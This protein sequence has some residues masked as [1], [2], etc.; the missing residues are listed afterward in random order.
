HEAPF[1]APRH[2]VLVLLAEVLPLHEHFERRRKRVGVLLLVALD[3][4]RDLL[5]AEEELLLV[6]ILHQI[7][8]RRRGRRQEHHADRDRHEEGEDG[9]ALLPP[10]LAHTLRHQGPSRR[11][12]SEEDPTIA[13][14]V[15][16]VAS[17]TTIVAAT[18]PTTFCALTLSVVDPHDRNTDV[19]GCPHKHR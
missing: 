6:G 16:S 3:A 14:V 13:S 17:A 19:V 4:V 1:P 12:N 15:S 7:V 5:P 2:R 9:V 8:P 11:S 10:R 18:F